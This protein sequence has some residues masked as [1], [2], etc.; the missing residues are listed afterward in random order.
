MEI[1]IINTETDDKLFKI[2]QKILDELFEQNL[3]RNE[4]Y[5]V[6]LNNFAAFHFLSGFTIKDWEEVT[7]Q[8]AETFNKM[9]EQ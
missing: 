9:G 4:I 3:N 8:L 6:L 1:K 5:T 2:A 7:M